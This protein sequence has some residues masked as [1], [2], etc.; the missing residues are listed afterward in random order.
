MTASGPEVV[1]SH[2]IAVFQILP[3]VIRESNGQPSD[4]LAP[5]AARLV[6]SGDTLSL[7]ASKLDRLVYPITI[8]PTSLLSR[9]TVF[10]PGTVKAV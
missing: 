9:L 7:I 5:P 6:L 1:N 3:P 8:D 2:G 4:K 10:L